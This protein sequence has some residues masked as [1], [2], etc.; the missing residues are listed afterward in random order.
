[1]YLFF[2]GILDDSCVE[3]RRIIL[4]YSFE[5]NESKKNFCVIF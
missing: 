3:V 5:M 4:I 2:I 1:M